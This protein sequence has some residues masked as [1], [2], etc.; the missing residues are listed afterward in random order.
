MYLDETAAE[1]TQRMR[2]KRKKQGKADVRVW[3]ACDARDALRE[4]A[5]AQGKTVSELVEMWALAA[6]EKNL[7]RKV[8]APAISI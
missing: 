8:A 7:A 2:E 1:R 4:V 5:D 6:R 3:I